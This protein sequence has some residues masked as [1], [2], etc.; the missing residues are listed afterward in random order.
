MV[1]VRMPMK[2]GNCT[3]SLFCGLDEGMATRGKAARIGANVYTD[4]AGRV[5]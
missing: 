2:D 1:V 4:M 3:E 5:P